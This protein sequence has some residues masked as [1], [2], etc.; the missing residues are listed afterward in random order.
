MKL[1]ILG[2]IGGALLFAL[3]MW[4]AV[5]YTKTD[6]PLRWVGFVVGLIVFGLSI[7]LAIRG[8]KKSLNDQAG[9]Q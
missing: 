6:A 1:G 3:I 9:P 2:P 4:V 5:H 8:E 7:V